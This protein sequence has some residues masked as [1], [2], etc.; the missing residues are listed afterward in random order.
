VTPAELERALSDL[1]A[2][3]A[4]PPTP[5]LAEAVKAR[6]RQKPTDARAPARPRPRW[7][8]RPLAVAAAVLVVLGL[9]L[10]TVPSVRTAIAHWL[11]ITGVTIDR[12]PA[13]PSASAIPTGAPP[14]QLGDL[15]HLGSGLSLSEARTRV[16]FPISVPAD[17]GVPDQVYLR[18]PPPGG[19]VSLVYLPR[20]GLPEAR[21]TGVGMLVTQ[22]RGA[23]APDFFGKVIGPDTTVQPVTVDGAS[24]YWI[25]GSPHV[26]F[27]RDLQG[28]ILTEDLR[29][30]DNTLIWERDGVTYRLES[31]LSR[32]QAIAI[33]QSM[34]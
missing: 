8:R 3:I 31:S 6:L 18:Q 26:L 16:T 25:A 15:L 7:L 33:A 21:S 24:G 4:Y 10:G 27:Y 11:G 20:P 32:D 22:F 5:P 23:L 34:R 1:G 12:V 17:L 14:S 19:A 30:A 9:L 13:L 28:Q 29:L 2:H